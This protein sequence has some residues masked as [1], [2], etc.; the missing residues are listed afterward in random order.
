VI[1]GNERDEYEMSDDDNDNDVPTSE[2]F[3]P[4]LYKKWFKTGDRSGFLSLRPWLEAGKIA[5]D[6][7]ELRNNTLTSHTMVWANIVELAAYVRAVASG[8]GVALYPKYEKQGRDTDEGFGYYGGSQMEGR[9]VSRIIKVHHWVTDYDSEGNPIKWDSRN[10]AWK[11][12]HFEG[13][14]TATGAFIPKASKP[15]STNMIQVARRDMGEIALRLD[16]TLLGH[17]A[18]T[19]DWYHWKKK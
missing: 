1:E 4:D 6:I 10:F 15:I 12:G 2:D 9:P 3:G 17:A 18:R 8:N 14:I 16:L 5:I 13:T 11:T 7:G 19:E